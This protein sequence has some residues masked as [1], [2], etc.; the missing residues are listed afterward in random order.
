MPFPHISSPFPLILQQIIQYIQQQIHYN[1]NT[2][3]THMYVIFLQWKNSTSEPRKIQ[4]QSRSKPKIATQSSRDQQPI[5]NP[6]T[7]VQQQR[8]SLSF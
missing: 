4:N 5:A 6:V 7:R 8:A 2:K 3:Q 1:T